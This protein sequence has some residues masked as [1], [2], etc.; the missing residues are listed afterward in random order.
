MTIEIIPP[1]WDWTAGIVGLAI[2]GVVILVAIFLTI[3]GRNAWNWRDDSYST[4]WGIVPV[5]FVFVSFVCGSTMS[6]VNTERRNV[7]TVSVLEEAGFEQVSY[8]DE[9]KTFTASKDGAYFNGI[10]VYIEDN[11]YQILEVKR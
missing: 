6:N 1:V 8:D 5:L 4:L 3:M 10:L 9:S 11:T 7:N 2:I